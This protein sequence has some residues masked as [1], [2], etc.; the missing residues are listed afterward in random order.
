MIELEEKSE[1]THLNEQFHSN[2]SQRWIE[3]KRP[4]FIGNTGKQQ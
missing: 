3:M 2:V 4:V 1:S